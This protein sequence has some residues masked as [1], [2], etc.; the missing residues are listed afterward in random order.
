MKKVFMTL[1]AAFALG[2]F[3]AKAAPQT[4]GVARPKLVVGI[5]VDQMRWDYLYRYYD[6]YGEGGFKRLLSEGFNCE[7][8]QLDYVPTVTAIG[9]TCIYTGS[10]PSIHGIA[11]NDFIFR[12]TGKKTYCTDDETVS[13]VG[14]DNAAGKMS[15]RNLLV[16]TVGDE[17]HLATNFRAKVISVSL[18]DRASILPGGHTADGAYWFDSKT[19]RWITSTYYRNELPAWLVKFNATDP[20]RRLMEQD[21]NTLYPLDTYVQS[22]ADDTPYETPFE[23]GGKATFPVRTSKLLKTDGYGVI[24]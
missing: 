19:G 2:L 21:W 1:C 7:N 18:K 15:P 23:K 22:T 3:P 11:G 12:H 13:S 24:R 8:T 4:A 14:C 10:V 16:T 17:L 9:H 5:V 20:A 6:R